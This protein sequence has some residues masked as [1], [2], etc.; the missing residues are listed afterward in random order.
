LSFS[1]DLSGRPLKSYVLVPLLIAV[2]LL[3]S[4]VAISSISTDDYRVG[5]TF[6]YS[7]FVMPEWLSTASYNQ[8]STSGRGF[9][10][11]YGWSYEIV[12]QQ[13]AA[14][15][16]PLLK[17]T[18]ESLAYNQ[19]ANHAFGRGAGGILEQPPYNQMW[20][21]YWIN[22]SVEPSDSGTFFD[23]SF[24]GPELPFLNQLPTY[25]WEGCGY[26]VNVNDLISQHNL[27]N[28]EM[29]I[30][31]SVW[32]N[33]IEASVNSNSGTFRPALITYG[34]A[35]LLDISVTVSQGVP[36]EIQCGNYSSA[37]IKSSE[38]PQSNI[39][40]DSPI[41]LYNP[42][43]LSLKGT[44]AYLAGASLLLIVAEAILLYFN[45]PTSPGPEEEKDKTLAPKTNC[46]TSP[47]LTHDRQR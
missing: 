15:N 13:L 28:G 42:T 37:T 11:W 21:D 44:V 3:V 24:L 26:Y 32:L 9:V 12:E 27:T 39:T 5:G 14:A 4:A 20:A 38:L 33:D 2:L 1:I 29:E 34:D 47:T 43:I 36:V 31:W 35:T 23:V 25:E 45:R 46:S 30:R 19:S 6:R 10:F 8:D 16:A 18:S 17:V 22:G 7:I 41:D 40:V